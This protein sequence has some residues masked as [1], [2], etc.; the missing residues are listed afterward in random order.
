VPP[1]FTKKNQPYEIPGEKINKQKCDQPPNYRKDPL[2][3]DAKKRKAFDER[4]EGVK[5][6]LK[7]SEAN[8]ALL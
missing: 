3:P 8:H 7:K 1:N 6:A 5:K 4:V 2:K